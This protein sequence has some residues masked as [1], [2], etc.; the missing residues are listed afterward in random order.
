VAVIQVAQDFG[1][2]SENPVWAGSFLV[3]SIRRKDALKIDNSIKSTPTTKVGQTT[4]KKAGG[5][6]AAKGAS[7]SASRD[8]VDI[9]PLSS[10]LA[11]LES[12]LENVSVVDTARVESIKQ[13]ISEGRFK[14]DADAI[15]DRLIETVKEMVL[16]RKG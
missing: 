9:N 13:A 3:L 11:A 2:L 10:Q 7:A 16:S 5:T 8:K 12:S 1:V 14:V 4:A 6:T 15:A